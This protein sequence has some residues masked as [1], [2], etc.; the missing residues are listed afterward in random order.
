MV[1]FGRTPTV[2]RAYTGASQSTTFSYSSSEVAEG[3]LLVAH[4]S[5]GNSATATGNSLKNS[6]GTDWN[7]VGGTPSNGRLVW[8]KVATSADIGSNHTYIGNGTSNG[9]IT[10]S[11]KN[12][13][14]VESYSGEK[15]G[16]TTSQA[17]RALS[18]I[19]IKIYYN[20][21]AT[22]GNFPNLITTDAS[23]YIEYKSFAP[24]TTI[25]TYTSV[26]GQWHASTNYAIIVVEDGD[27]PPAVSVTSPA[28]D[29]RVDPRL[30]LNVS[31]T[32]SDADGDVQTSYSILANGVQVASGTGTATS[33]TIPANTLT[34]ETDYTI[35]VV[36]TNAKGSGQ[37]TVDVVSNSWTEGVE[38]PSSA[39]SG[40]VTPNANEPGG[41]YELQVAT[42]DA[43]IFGPWSAS[44]NTFEVIPFNTAPESEIDSVTSVIF[45]NRQGV[46]E[47]IYSDNEGDTQAGYEIRVRKKI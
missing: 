1:A 20:N 28:T 35:T 30:P 14:I 36:A 17:A 2:T 5:D 41:T 42:T 9:I 47:W 31:W 8:W 46:V 25:A 6:A 43:T 33:V 3:D 12:A 21:S 10:M 7:K 18:A 38:V 13:V 19:A 16:N 37:A 34:D 11:F 22:T 4:T 27:I 23:N 39:Q 44:S 15:P 45:N 40:I 32:Y 24:N 26:T 29:E